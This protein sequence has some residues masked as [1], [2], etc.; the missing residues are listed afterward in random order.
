MNDLRGQIARAICIDCEDNPDDVG[1][2]RGNE[3]RWQD[4]LTCADAALNVLREQEPVSP[5]IDAHELWAAA[6]LTPGEGI[7][8]GVDRIA[9]LLASTPKPEDAT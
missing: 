9:A 8:D 7:E 2:C 4:Y 5:S 6:Q 3:F 1:D